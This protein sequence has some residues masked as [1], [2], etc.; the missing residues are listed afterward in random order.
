MKAGRQQGDRVELHLDRL[1]PGRSALPLDHRLVREDQVLQGHRVEGFEAHASGELDVDTMDQ[2]ILVH[3]EFTARRNMLCDR[4]GEPVGLDYP[5]QVE[6]VIYR[7]PQRGDDPIEDDDNWVIQ[8]ASGIVDLNEA[9]LEAVVLDEP[10]RVVH[11]DHEEVPAEAAGTV[12]ESVEDET[13]DPRW[14]ALRR[15]REGDGPD[16]GPTND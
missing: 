3:G 14:E 15:L 12:E 6:I 5:V 13:V 4:C 9:L 1:P 16:E 11:S 7:T 10:Q 2:K 8:Q